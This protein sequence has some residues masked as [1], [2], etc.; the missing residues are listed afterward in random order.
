[1]HILSNKT[2]N[3]TLGNLPLD[4]DFELLLSYGSNVVF[5]RW[6]FGEVDSFL[7]SLIYLDSTGSV[8][9]L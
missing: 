8:P 3:S 6:Y 5:R 2:P 1:M 9:V 4:N 7:F